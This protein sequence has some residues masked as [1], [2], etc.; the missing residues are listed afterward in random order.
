MHRRITLRVTCCFHL[1]KQLY[2]LCGLCFAPQ[3][4]HTGTITESMHFEPESYA[5]IS[6][7]REHESQKIWLPTLSRVLQ[8]PID[9][10]GNET[11][12][13]QSLPLVDFDLVLSSMSIMCAILDPSLLQWRHYYCSC[14]P[15]LL[16]GHRASNS[17]LTAFD[18]LPTLWVTSS[19]TLRTLEVKT[20]DQEL[21]VDNR[22]QMKR[23]WF[24]SSQS[25]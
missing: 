1:Q 13:Q 21:E 18:Q 7:Q 12:R 2:I 11:V 22:I 19:I 3:L 23:D 24:N 5:T 15:C 8:S 16:S 14:R 10:G 25:W 6:C 20:D 9:T 17:R 4:K